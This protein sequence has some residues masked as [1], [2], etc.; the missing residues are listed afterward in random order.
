MIHMCDVFSG[1]RHPTPLMNQ[2]LPSNGMPFR[3]Q[4]PMPPMGQV[5]PYVPPPIMPQGPP[6]MMPVR[7][8]GEPIP[9]G[10]PEGSSH[11][12]L[13]ATNVPPPG[14]SM[15]GGPPRGQWSA[16]IAVPRNAA[17][18]DGIPGGPL[19]PGTGPLPVHSLP[20]PRGRDGRGPPF[21]FDGP[22]KPNRAPEVPLSRS[23]FYH[24]QE[25]CKR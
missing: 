6:P 23:E 19:P 14:F 22:P 18:A 16:P 24:L 2:P 7:P 15:A 9:P 5:M 20:P 10:L 8:P 1:P 12:V 21:R 25:K 17:Y 11:M 4:A 13:P 3:G